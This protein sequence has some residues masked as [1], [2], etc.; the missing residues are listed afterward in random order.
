MERNNV[1]MNKAQKSMQYIG[2][3]GSK[4]KTGSASKLKRTKEKRK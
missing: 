4:M 3:F 1:M 2:K